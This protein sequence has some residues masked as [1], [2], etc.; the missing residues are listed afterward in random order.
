MTSTVYVAKSLEEKQ[1]QRALLH[2]H[3]KENRKLVRRALR[4]AGRE[5]LMEVLL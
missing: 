5:D 4:E 1:M 2:F 3:K